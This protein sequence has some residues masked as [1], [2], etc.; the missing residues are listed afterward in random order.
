MS[1]H[2]V[3]S[4]NNGVTMP[5]LGLGVFRVPEQ[6]DAEDAV[7]TALQAGYLHIDTAAA[8]GNEEGVGRGLKSS[9]VPRDQIFLTTKLWNEAM[10]QGRQLEAFEESL[11]KLGTDYVDLYLVHWPVPGK[12]VE[13]WQV[14]EKLYRDGRIRAAG[15]SNFHRHHLEAIAQVSS[16]VP[17]VNQIELHPYLSQVPLVDEC[18]RRGIAVTAWSPLGGVKRNVATDPV[19]AE[20]GRRYGKSA[21]QVALRWQIQRGLITI[22][23][24][25]NPGRIA[26]NAAIFDFELGATDVAQINGLNENFRVGSDPENFNF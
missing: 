5:V 4:L 2:P 20:I 14:V 13:S 7:R 3:K 12:F 26:E 15:V 10:R 18:T 6:K 25:S 23:K 17:A 19:L 24:S 8:Y 22:P 21:V 16:L 9:G 11:K 1:N